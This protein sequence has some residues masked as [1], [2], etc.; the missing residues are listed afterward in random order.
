GGPLADARG[1]VVGINSMV[2]GSLALA[3]PSDAALRFVARE[4]S[5]P[6]LGVTVRPVN[7][8]RGFGWLVLGVEPGSAAERASLLPGDLLLGTLDVER[9]PV[10]IRFLR[11][12]S[13]RLREVMAVIAS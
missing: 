1:S 6:M 3:V 9:G 12:G 4:G 11:P 8:A 5:P 10:P 13:R 7:T 2:A